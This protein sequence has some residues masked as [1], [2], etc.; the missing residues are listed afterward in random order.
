MMQYYAEDTEKIF[1]EDVADELY[2]KDTQEINSLTETEKEKLYPKEAVGNSSRKNVEPVGENE[3]SIGTFGDILVSYT[4]SSFGFDIGVPGHAGIVHIE[5]IWTVESF[6]EGNGYANGVRRYTND[7]KDRGHS[8]GVRVKGATKADY[9]AAAKYAIAQIGKPYNWN[10]FNK[11]T[12]DS[13][14]C[15]QL[16]WRAWKNQGFDIDRMNL[17]DWEPVSPAELVGGSNTYVF[18]KD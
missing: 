13:F 6:P 18:Y 10:Y 14:Y 7:W 9:T 1:S 11:G 3:S 2:E 15:S 5:E 4:F 17:G 16:V 12:T 8:Y